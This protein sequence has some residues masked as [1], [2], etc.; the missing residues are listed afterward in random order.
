[1]TVKLQYSA[2]V[3]R[4]A[5]WADI[6]NA[7]VVPGPGVVA[8]LAE[9]GL[10]LGRGLL[11]LAEMSSAGSLATGSYTSATVEWAR[12]HRNFVIGFV[13]GRRLCGDADGDGDFLHVTPG[14]CLDAEG[15]ALDQQYRT[16]REVVL[17][18]G[19]D[20]IIVGRGICAPGKDSRAEAR[21]YREAGWRAYEERIGRSMPL[22]A[23]DEQNE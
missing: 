20:V 14:V 18:C 10:P 5:S 12:R 15:D 21:R 2:G 19:S 13:A 11:L 9:V 16:P 23:P 22:A 8:G 6:T 4:I 7:H 17:T 3:H 1:N